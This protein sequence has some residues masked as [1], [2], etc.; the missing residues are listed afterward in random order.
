MSQRMRAPVRHGP[1][2]LQEFSGFQAIQHRHVMIGHQHIEAAHIAVKQVGRFLPVA[3]AFDRAT[4]A[5]EGVREEALT[6][7]IVIDT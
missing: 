6:D 2:A 3:D 5:R 7:G 1:G 4:R